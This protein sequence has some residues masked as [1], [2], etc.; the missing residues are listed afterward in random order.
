MTTPNETRLGTLDEFHSF[1]ADSSKS[2]SNQYVV[3]GEANVQQPPSSQ[4]G[5]MAA[6]PKQGDQ[7]AQYVSPEQPKLSVYDNT[8][9]LGADDLKREVAFT[10]TS[11]SQ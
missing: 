2:S 8:N 5:P 9:W 6:M 10:T 11:V 7:Y 4:Y 1:R 3:F